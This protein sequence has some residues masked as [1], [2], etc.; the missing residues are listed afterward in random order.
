M[1]KVGLT[2]G[3]GCGKTTV[4][5]LFA[6]QGVPIIDADAIAHALVQQ[7][8]PALAEIRDTWGKEILTKDG[9]LDRARLR[10]LIF[11][12]PKEKHKLESILHPLV[13]RDIQMA[14]GKVTADYCVISIPLLFETGMASLVD[15]VL[16]IDCPTDTQIRRVKHRDHLSSE[17]IQAIIDT[18][19]TRDFRATHADDLIENTETN[20]KLAEQVKKLHNLYLSISHCQ[21]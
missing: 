21:D 3:I 20:D 13:F 11:T 12:C 18:Q 15:R 8:Q 1:L 19:V 16:V 7:G 2:G 6:Q 17:Q 9:S 14:A 4:A 10:D 5:L